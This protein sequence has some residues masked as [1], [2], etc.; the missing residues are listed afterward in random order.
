[1]W[2]V[3]RLCCSAAAASAYKYLSVCKC[4]TS[5]V[6]SYRVYV[7][8]HQQLPRL[9]PPSP[10]SV[11][12]QPIGIAQSQ[13]NQIDLLATRLSCLL[14]FA[15]PIPPSE[16]DIKQM[17]WGHIPSRWAFIWKQEALM[18]GSSARH[19]HT[20]AEERE[21]GKNDKIDF[22]WAATQMIFAKVLRS[23]QKYEDIFH[24]QRNVSK[25]FM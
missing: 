22:P 6:F 15:R 16:L 1:M 21:W 2:T 18:Q 19:P 25:L 24:H 12:A 10:V 5:Y 3:T 8:K 11:Y 23:R 13:Q 20:E 17:N 14:I 4:L 7:F 9:Y